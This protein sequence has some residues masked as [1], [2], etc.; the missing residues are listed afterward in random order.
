MKTKLILCVALLVLA[1]CDNGAPDLSADE[2]ARLD[3]T[4]LRP[5]AEQGVANAQYNLGLMYAQGKGVPENNAEA[6]RWF[7]LAAAQGVAFAQYNLG[8]M[9]A[10]GKGVP[11]NYAEAARWWRPLAEQG[12]ANAQAGLGQLYANGK[13]VPEND[14]AAYMW[15]NL[16]AA[17]G[18]EA[19]E[20][21]KDTFI[22][23]MSS[24]DISRAQQLSAKCLARNYKDC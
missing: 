21:A 6:V 13:G 17:Q 2:I 4:E 19:A 14:A 7:R 18:E 24:A 5:L 16:A 10:Q 15:M 22:K 20:T 8:L 9:Y 12:D 3:A 1:A 23:G 11:Q